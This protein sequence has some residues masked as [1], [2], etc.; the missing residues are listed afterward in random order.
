MSQLGPGGWSFKCLSQGV[1]R[2]NK[3]LS[4]GGLEQSLSRV[5]FT[6]LSQGSRDI[7]LSRGAFIYCLGWV[8][9]GTLLSS[10]GNSF[11]FNDNVNDVLLDHCKWST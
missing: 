1:R 10:K 3:S 9:G 7:S 11:A 4:R 2:H 6:S 8:V 5:A